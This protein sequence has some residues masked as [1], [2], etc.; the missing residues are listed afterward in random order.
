MGPARQG[1]R[2]STQDK[3]SNPEQLE[4]A[5]IQQ[6]AYDSGVLAK[7]RRLNTKQL[8]PD[9]ALRRSD[10]QDI[11]K[12][13]SIRKGRYLLNICAKIAPAAA[14]RLGTLAGLDSRN[15]VLYMDFPEGRLKFLGTLVFPKNNYMVLKFGRK[16]VLC[17]DVLENMIVFSEAI[18][19]GTAAEN[20]EEKELPMPASLQTQ[21]HEKYAFRDDD[22][23]TADPGTQPPTSQAD[24]SGS[25]AD[26]DDQ[27]GSQ[28]PVRQSQR[29]AG[30]RQGKRPR[31]L[32]G[33][34][35][36]DPVDS[37]SSDADEDEAAHRSKKARQMPGSD[38]KVAAAVPPID[39]TEEGA[40]GPAKLAAHRRAKQGSL[41]MFMEKA[42][43]PSA[44]QPKPNAA[45]TRRTPNKTPA[46]SEG[47]ANKFPLAGRKQTPKSASKLAAGSSD[48][49]AIEIMSSGD[50][51]G[52]SL[53][54]QPTPSQR[55]Q[56]A[57]RTA[58]AKKLVVESPPSAS[59]SDDPADEDSAS[60]GS[61]GN[62]DDFEA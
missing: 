39:Q 4:A 13:S 24:G 58:A 57:A 61:P 28:E 18:W 23:E 29:T 38:A 48:S 14:G 8:P 36:D 52:I 25:E 16:E 10:G 41:D 21:R 43:K 9:K 59:D 51:D 55:P 34:E 33:I 32:E 53:L 11:V 46:K 37:E 26:G 20:P 15:P 50:E 12:K 60:E 1:S 2:A 3:S 17:E 19:V 6:Q 62:D 5:R 56:R 44:T 7:T 31:Y 27:V 40:P 42:A 30:A 35:S 47:A 54:S 49:D 22:P 45:A